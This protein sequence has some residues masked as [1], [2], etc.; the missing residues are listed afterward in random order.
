MNIT[1][2]TAK[3][4]QITFRA[5][6]NTNNT[7]SLRVL[8]SQDLFIKPASVEPQY[9]PKQLSFT[10]LK[11]LKKLEVDMIFKPMTE[12]EPVIP[13]LKDKIEVVKIKST[14][15]TTLNCWHIEPKEGKP[16]ILFC[17]G[18]KVN[19]TQKQNIA[20]FLS[21]NGYGV[22]MA[23]YRGYGSNPGTPTEKGLY[24]DTTA[25]L[26]FLN[27]EKGIETKDLYI[28]GHSLGGGIVSELASKN[29]FK[30]VILDSTFTNIVDMTKDTIIKILEAKD[31]PMKKMLIK[32]VQS[33]PKSV[34]AAINTKFD[35]IKKVD[36]INSP[37]LV[38]HSK[39]DEVIPYKM[40]EQLASKNEGSKLVLFDSGVHSDHSQSESIIKEFIDNE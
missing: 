4:N 29:Q 31:P 30:G 6:L 15:D 3:L 17:H 12:L 2:N 37:L 19:I 32:M 11:A 5:Q 18:N 10:G 28:W 8:P 1:H 40:S 25:S 27:E 24:D 20:K 9:K 22:L 33:L 21:D 34:F 26:K 35:N 13:A 39:V 14:D 23:D 16:T 36:K 38:I 7:N